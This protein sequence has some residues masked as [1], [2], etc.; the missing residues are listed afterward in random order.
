MR[1]GCGGRCFVVFLDDFSVS[2]HTG[3][4]LRR[5]RA[6]YRFSGGTICASRTDRDRAG[7]PEFAKRR[8][9]FAGPSLL[10]VTPNLGIGIGSCDQLQRYPALLIFF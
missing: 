4:I 2:S 10:D 9:D 3:S 5:S 7:R 8:A 1:N 6:R